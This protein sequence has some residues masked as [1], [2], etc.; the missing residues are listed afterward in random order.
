MTDR[1][2]VAEPTL[3]D[4]CPKFR[5]KMAEF[6]RL[7]AAGK[8]VAADKVFRQAQAIAREFRMGQAK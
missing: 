6:S 8:E 7:V 3:S 1:A 5:A 2:I 4:V